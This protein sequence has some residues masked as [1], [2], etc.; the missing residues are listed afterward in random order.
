ML[1]IICNLSEE[2]N[3]ASESEEHEHD[4]VLIDVEVGE[5]DDIDHHDS[6]MVSQELSIDEDDPDENAHGKI[7]FL[8]LLLNNFVGDSLLCFA[9]Y[10]F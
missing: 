1:I 5:D 10:L 6:Q 3:R 4:D 9:F 2:I 7:V 8:E